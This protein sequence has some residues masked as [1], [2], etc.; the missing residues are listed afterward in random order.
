[1]RP[2]RLLVASTLL[3]A[4]FAVP[5]SAFADTN[6]DQLLG[7]LEQMYQLPN[8][9]L[10]KIAIVENGGK[11]TGCA[12]TSSACGMFQW[13]TNSWYA[14]TKAMFGQPYDLSGRNDP[15]LSAKVTA[16]ALGDAKNQVG[17]LIQQSKIDMTVGL[18]LAHFLGIG[19]AR[20]F[21]N[22]YIQ[23]PSQNACALFP[24]GCAANGSILKQSL[25]GVVNTFAARLKAPGVLNV[26]G[27][28]QDQSG[29]SYAYS[30]ADVNSS[31]F[32]PA[33]TV[34]GSDPTYDYPQTFTPA[35]VSPTAPSF[36][37][38]GISS[39]PQ[40]TPQITPTQPLSTTATSSSTSGSA[41]T[42]KYFCSN[43][44]VY[45]QA[46]SCATSVFQVCN[47]GCLG[48]ICAPTPAAI[49]SSGVT[50]Q[51][52]GSLSSQLSVPGSIVNPLVATSNSSVA[53]SPLLDSSISTIIQAQAPALNQNQNQNQPTAPAGLAPS[54]PTYIHDT[55]TMN[56]SNGTVLSSDSPLGGILNQLKAALTS[57]LSYLGSL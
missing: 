5:F 43:S 32:L 27:N 52:T 33:S 16:F 30:Y 1:M 53:L 37:S 45:Y 21:L 40:T 42:P 13:T 25:A 47:Y 41:C 34:I 17:S 29:I 12:P 19:G 38:P 15:S 56:G 2:I 14:A 54:N 50:T 6:F 10:A 36:T 20:T 18:Y 46:N 49:S 28:F 3:L 48:T 51:S 9:I 44:T 26:A 23:D 57:L 8:G 22:A 4:C 11:A 24:K 55:L 39:I 7:Q 35:V 31:N